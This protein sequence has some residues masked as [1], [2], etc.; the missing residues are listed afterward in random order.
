MH[1]ANVSVLEQRVLG[2][3]HG[4]LS[5]CTALDMVRSRLTTSYILRTDRWSNSDVS[6]DCGLI[7][8]RAYTVQHCTVS[9][10]R[11]GSRSRAAATDLSERSLC[12]RR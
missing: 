11:E 5:R 7:S 12:I 2:S 9:S 8:I 10:I 4:G 1:T 6:E 3:A